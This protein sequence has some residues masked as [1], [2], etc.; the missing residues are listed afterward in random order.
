MVK[1][2]TIGFNS[3]WFNSRSIYLFYTKDPCVSVFL[4]P[5][6]V[7]VCMCTCLRVCVYTRSTM[8]TISHTRN[9]TNRHQ[10]IRPTITRSF[11]EI[12]ALIASRG[13]TLSSPT[14]F[15]PSFGAFPLRKMRLCEAIGSDNEV[16]EVA[17]TIITLD[18]TRRVLLL[19]LAWASESFCF[20]VFCF[21]VFLF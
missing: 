12:P 8:H 15:I 1:I 5:V 19:S 11:P 14:L 13:I 9:P 21:D 10:S 17:I 6:Y 16:L 18:W 7:C 2:Y 20:D 4:L 3:I